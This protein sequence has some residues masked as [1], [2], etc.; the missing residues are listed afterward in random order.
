MH[1]AREVGHRSLSSLAQAQAQAQAQA[2]AQTRTR[3]A[4]HALELPWFILHAI[5]LPPWSI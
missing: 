3:Q 4:R 1:M 5:P 2:W